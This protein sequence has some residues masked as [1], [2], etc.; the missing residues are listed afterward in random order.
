MSEDRD[1]QALTRIEDRQTCL[2]LANET[3]TT[4]LM[5]RAAAMRDAGFGD[6][7][8]VHSALPECDMDRIST[9]TRFWPRE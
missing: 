2:A 9:A 1:L 4:A 3:D 8:L 6:I 5:A 7:R